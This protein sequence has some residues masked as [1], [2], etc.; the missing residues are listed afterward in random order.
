[1]S[2]Q[3][4]LC[5]NIATL[6]FGALCR[7]AGIDLFASPTIAGWLVVLIGCIGVGLT[8]GAIAAVIWRAP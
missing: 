1:M 5:A 3:A 2:W 6:A 8:A 4:V 7:E